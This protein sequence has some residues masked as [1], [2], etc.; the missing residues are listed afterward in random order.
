MAAYNGGMSK[1]TTY[2]TLDTLSMLSV[3]GGFDVR[4][5]RLYL[6]LCASSLG[7]RSV[8]EYAFI[9]QPKRYIDKIGL[10]DRG[11]TGTWRVLDGLLDSLERVGLADRD[12][13]ASDWN[14]AIESASDAEK[15]TWLK[16]SST[17]R[18]L[19]RILD[20]NGR[21]HKRSEPEHAKYIR[22][23]QSSVTKMCSLSDEELVLLLLLL[24]VVRLPVFGGVDQGTVSMKNGRVV[25]SLVIQD[26]YL[27]SLKTP[28]YGAK[29]GIHKPFNALVEKSYF[30]WVELEM[31]KVGRYNNTW[32]LKHSW[33]M[34]PRKSGNEST[35][36][37][38][39][40][41]IP[42]RALGLHRPD[43]C[44][45]DA[46]ARGELSTSIPY[47]VIGE[48]RK[49]FIH[50]HS[51]F[52]HLTRDESIERHVEVLRTRTRTRTRRDIQPL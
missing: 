20:P 26:A 4:L 27:S 50:E 25:F 38:R 2:L 7:S 21:P 44:F 37:T 47:E 9:S 3:G 6:A 17:D 43:V 35:S 39:R 29:L 28:A 13:S 46:L 31:M 36:G 42:Q 34:L 48:L 41:L 32:V 52:E 22:L 8:Q 30:V 14:T 19:V 18:H 24:S 10:G 51:G 16:I 45:V 15:K 40:V 49:L 12:I 1:D 23:L 11:I 5:L 33:E